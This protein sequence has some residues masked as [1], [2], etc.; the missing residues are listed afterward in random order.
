MEK[1]GGSWMASSGRPWVLRGGGGGG[2]ALCSS[3]LPAV[4]CSQLAVGSARSTSRGSR[5]RRRVLL[6]GRGAGIGLRA[7]PVSCTR[8]LNGQ[9]VDFA[10]IQAQSSNSCVLRCVLRPAS[11]HSS[12]GLHRSSTG[13]ACC[14]VHCRTRH[15][16][17][18]L[19]TALPTPQQGLQRALRRLH[20]AS[21]H[22]IAQL[23]QRRTTRGLPP[24][25][26]ATAAA[27]RRHSSAAGEP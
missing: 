2:A 27:C 14:S 5:P 4:P 23:P 26:S 12:P 3:A 1:P 11:F 6:G 10:G 24:P 17:P 22:S 8:Q 15:R 19:P 9:R 16:L 25:P 20:I 13:C 7:V 18:H 21:G